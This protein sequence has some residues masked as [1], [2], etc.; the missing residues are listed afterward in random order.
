MHLRCRFGIGRLFVA[1]AEYALLAIAAYRKF[2][3]TCL[4]VRAAIRHVCI[5]PMA[6]TFKP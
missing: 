4:T 6:S 3:F 5:N 2:V 1:C